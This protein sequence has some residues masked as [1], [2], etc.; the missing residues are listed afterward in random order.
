VAADFFKQV[1]PGGDLYLLHQILHDWSD[2]ECVALL[3]ACRRSMRASS[4]LIVVEMMIP[5]HDGLSMA[6]LLDLEMLVM[7]AGRE[8][9]EGELRRLLASC[10]LDL[11]RVTPTRG[12]MAVLEVVPV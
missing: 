9:S 6:K 3:R 2:D 1:P 8:R 11:V 7:G 4:K 10:D 12:D 5:E